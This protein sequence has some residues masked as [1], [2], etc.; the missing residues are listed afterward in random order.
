[1]YSGVGHLCYAHAMNNSRRQKASDNNLALYK[2]V[3]ASHG[4]EL[5]ATKGIYYTAERTPPLYSNLATRS[6]EWMPEEIFGEIDKHYNEQSWS[7]WSIKDSFQCL[8]LTK[9]GF[10]KL[11]DSQWLY[12]ESNTF[13][14]QNN[15]GIRFE[16]VTDSD[17]L[18]RWIETWGEGVELGNSIYKPELL[19]DDSVYFVIG[20]KD[21]KPDCVALLNKSDD[22]IGVSNFFVP[23]DTVSKWSSLVSFI[24]S[25]IEVRDVVGYEDAETLEKISVLGFESVGNLTIWL[26]KYDTR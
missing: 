7:D 6:P 14:P 24:Y 5:Q 8:D 15:E 25:E 10:E 4:I 20:Y 13:T 19:E 11:F 21:T 17:G 16:I 1:M 18:Q 2:S 23:D 12:L 3:F 26:K 22:V 9:H